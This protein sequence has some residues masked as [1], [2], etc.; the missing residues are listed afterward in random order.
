VEDRTAKDLLKVASGG[1]SAF[2]GALLVGGGLIAVVLGRWT[3]R[4]G[5]WWVE[6][7]RSEIGVTLGPFRARRPRIPSF[8]WLAF[9]AAFG[10]G[11]SLFKSIFEAAAAQFL[12]D[13]GV[14]GLQAEVGRE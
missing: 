12:S 6:E 13:L 14:S 3:T 11:I 5:S 1:L 10:F 8:S 9:A 4:C 7:D 2:S